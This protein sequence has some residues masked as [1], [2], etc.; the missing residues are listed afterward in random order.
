MAATS[1]TFLIKVTGVDHEVVEKWATV[2]DHVGLALFAGLFGTGHHYCWIRT[3]GYWRYVRLDLQHAGDSAVLRHGPL[4]ALPDLPGRPR[5]YNNAA[6]LWSLELPGARLLRRRRVGLH[7]RAL[8]GQLLLARHPGG[9]PRMGTWQTGTVE[10]FKYSEAMVASGVVW[11][12][13]TIAEGAVGG[14]RGLHRRRDNTGVGGPQGTRRL[15]TWSPT[16]RQTATPEPPGVGSIRLHGHPPLSGVRPR[17]DARR[18]SRKAPPRSRRTRPPRVPHCSQAAAPAAG[19]FQPSPVPRHTENQHIDRDG[20]G[21]RG[22]RP[23]GMPE[24]GPGHD[25]GG[26]HL[27]DGAR[28]SARERSRAG[29]PRVGEERRPSPTR[30]RPIPSQA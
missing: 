10:G 22:E 18:K 9:P 23:A 21:D 16:F 12:K 28:S 3:P 2:G 19:D 20:D 27:S 25:G 26:K 30:I 24:R 17:S 15:P 11:D 14:S 1:P 5:A 8:R 6:L 4:G 13:T 7:A 29:Q